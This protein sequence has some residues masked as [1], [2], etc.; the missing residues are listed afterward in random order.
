MWLYKDVPHV[1]YCFKYKT[2]LNPSKDTTQTHSNSQYYHLMADN[3]K[4]YVTHENIKTML[5]HLN[6]ANTYVE[7]MENQHWKNVTKSKM[8]KFITCITVEPVQ[9]L[10]LAAILDGGLLRTFAGLNFY[11]R[12]YF[13]DNYHISIQKVHQSGQDRVG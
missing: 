13:I 12:A 2:T 11:T 8:K 4:R 5:N 9:F 10:I 1:F 6:Y 7:F 3:I